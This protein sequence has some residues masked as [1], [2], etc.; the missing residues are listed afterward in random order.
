MQPVI[1]F[2]HRVRR[3]V[4]A[5]VCMLFLP[6]S[7]AGAPS[8]LKVACLR[9]IVLPGIAARREDTAH[10]LR[11]GVVFRGNTADFLPM[12]VRV[13]G[14][15]EPAMTAFLTSRLSSGR[16]FVD[17]GANIGWFDLVAAP[18]VGETG[19]VVAIEASPAIHARLAEQVRGSNLT[20]VR[21]V[22]EAVG[23]AS[24][25]VHI[26]DG[27]SWNSAQSAVVAD[28]ERR[29]GSVACRT[30][31]EILT[32]EE[33]AACRIVKI[34]VE[35]AEFEVVR[36]LGPLLDRLAEDA[37]IVVEV[38]PGRSG[39]SSESVHELWEPF[40][41][42]GYCAYELPNDYTA[43]FLRDPIVPR[44]LRRLTEPPLRQTDVVFSRTAA[45]ELPI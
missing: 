20:N 10:E 30:L 35:G 25:W 15:W 36:G 39:S 41:S 27:P 21:T 9:W 23:S 16:V 1:A 22:N 14:R 3:W 17:V 12:V 19:G 2:A 11:P 6:W 28:V 42:R 44:T 37:E 18:L 24:G 45:A 38:G 32:A 40:V 5:R 33:I 8:R 29:P 4:L 34:D 43:A 13:F 26:V 7:L 31:D